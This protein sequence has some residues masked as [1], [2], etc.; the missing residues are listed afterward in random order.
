VAVGG[1][2]EVGVAAVLVEAEGLVVEGLE[3]LA[4]EAV[5]AE[6]PRG[7]GDGAGETRRE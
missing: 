1:V 6:E 7:V 4:V 5:E 3:D 2:V